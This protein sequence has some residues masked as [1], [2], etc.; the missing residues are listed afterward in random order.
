MRVTIQARGFKICLELLVRAWPTRLVEIPY[1]FDDREQGESK[2]SLRE[3]ADIWSS[4]AGCTGALELG[5]P[6]TA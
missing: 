4:S 5:R 1:Q 2:M 6:S 3:A